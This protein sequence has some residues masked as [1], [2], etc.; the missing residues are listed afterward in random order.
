ML[1]PLKSSKIYEG[2][3]HVTCGCFFEGPNSEAKMSPFSGKFLSSE[4]CKIF[5]ATLGILLHRPPTKVVLHQVFFSSPKRDEQKTC[6][7][8]L[9]CHFILRT[10]PLGTLAKIVLEMLFPWGKK[11]HHLYKNSTS[12][13]SYC[14]FKGCSLHGSTGETSHHQSNLRCCNF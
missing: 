12:K 1:D 6:R 8:Y 5:W 7:T 9:D 10:S 4:F 3:K 14:I 13:T 2:R 11:S